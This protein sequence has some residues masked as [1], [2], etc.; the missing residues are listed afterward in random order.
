M[1][2]RHL[3][4]LLRRWWW[5][6]LAP[7][8][9]AAALAGALAE[10]RAP[11]YTSEGSY[12]VRAD[13][14][15]PSDLVR[16]TSPLTSSDEIVSTYARIARSDLITERARQRLGRSAS[17]LEGVAVASSVA[18]DANVV[19]IGARSGD[20]ELAR[21][22]AKA[23]GELT[24]EYVDEGNDTYV[25]ETLDA[26]ELP[27]TPDDRGVQRL[28]TV[29]ALAGLAAG[30]GLAV[31]LE[32]RMPSAPPRPRLREIV[33][34]RSSAYTKRYLQMRLREEVSRS[35]GAGQTFSVG[36]LQILRR[37][38]HGAEVE[39]P[40]ALTDAELTALS[41]GIRGTLHDHDIL[42]HLGQGR[43]AAILPGFSLD[44]ARTLVQQWRRSTAPTLLRDRMGRDFKV[45][46]S[47]C[48][49]ERSGF[50]GDAD[51]ELIVGD[52]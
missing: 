42:G 6:I 43:F 18:L 1:S 10:R 2:A 9:V 29:G 19:L 35:R 28:A 25:L 15:D 31:G 11:V 3:G 45:S 44:E 12:V 5:V 52:L 50:V 4:R 20:P 47:A 14:A 32:N 48:E 30:L 22:L 24:R 17:D 37:R 23:A 46:V 13:V 21:D 34:E 40:A 27:D 36:V 26:P 51:A 33:D 16:A 7:A 8:V 41:V 39:E 38:P 49:F